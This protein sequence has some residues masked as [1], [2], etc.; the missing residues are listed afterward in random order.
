MGVGVLA[1]VLAAAALAS[2][3]VG[4]RTVPPGDVV[5]A[6]V[7]TAPT[8]GDL[9][10]LIHN[11]VIRTALGLVVG[12]AIGA[13]GA[14]TQGHTRN[15]LA[16]P[17]LLGINAG[18]ACA[19]VTGVFVFGF[20]GPLPN[21]AMALVGAGVA[22]AAV[23]GLSSVTGSS[24]ATLVLAGAGLSACL[25][26]VSSALVLS[27]GAT[28]QTWRYWNVG[29]LAGR[30]DDI[31]WATVPFVAVGLVLAF[32]SGRL[33]NVLALGDAMTVALGGRVMLI[34]ATG[35]VGIT[36]LAG[37]ATAACGPI[38]FLGL[39]VPH[40][41]RVV[42]GADYRWLVPYSAMLGAVLILVCDVAGRLISRPAELQVS[43]V[44]ALLGGPALIVM[45]R[46]RTVASV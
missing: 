33:L 11:R 43:V 45:A 36:L 23:F 8:D 40:V 31:L 20:A 44:L 19:V 27:D 4:S 2:I 3:A 24:P 34:R 5:D 28:L 13:A 32:V 39:V 38:V 42:T 30:G 17:G 41:A 1:V 26:A 16:D 15:P 46:R 14:L 12:L 7:G 35:I 25:T 22:A 10:V 21:T 9:D 6:L 18:A 37:A 29:A